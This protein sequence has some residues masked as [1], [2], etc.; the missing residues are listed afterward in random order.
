[1]LSGSTSALLNLLNQ[2]G[3][4]CGVTSV[5]LPS[6]LSHELSET[7]C[8]TLQPNSSGLV[9]CMVRAAW[10]TCPAPA[11][12]APRWYKCKMFVFRAAI[13]DS[14]NYYNSSFLCC[15]HASKALTKY[16]LDDDDN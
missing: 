9:R 12:C 13:K 5:P 10:E 4:L 6:N 11:F 7:L 2:G 1:M 15:V 14:S 3:S 16:N 8:L